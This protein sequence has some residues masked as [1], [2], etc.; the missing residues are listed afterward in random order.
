MTGKSL[1][2]ISEINTAMKLLKHNN[3]NGK[4]LVGVLEE[5]H[6]ELKKELH[7]E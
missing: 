5:L 3:N 1:Y 2:I 6:K 4:V 7:D